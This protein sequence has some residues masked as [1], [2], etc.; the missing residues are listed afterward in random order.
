MKEVL[1]MKKIFIQALSYWPSTSPIATRLHSLVQEL[2]ANGWF[3]EILTLNESKPSETTIIENQNLKIIY[4]K[5]KCINLKG[6]IARLK[7]E[8]EFYFITKRYVRKTKNKFDYVLVS[9]PYLIPCYAGLYLK[10]KYKAKLIFDVRDIWPDVAIEMDSFGKRSIYSLCFNYISNRLYKNASFV[11][12]VSTGKVKKIQGKLKRNKEK[13][14]LVENGFEKEMLDDAYDKEFSEKYKIKNHF[15]IS[16]C[17]KVGMAQGLDKILLLAE[18]F[19]NNDNVQFLIAGDG[20]EREKIE[21]RVRKEKLNKI[22]F[23]GNVSRDHVKTILQ[24]SSMAFISLKSSKMKD[25][26]PTKLYESLAFGC[27]TLLLASGDACTLLDETGLGIHVEP[28]NIDKVI[29]AA[30]EIYNNYESFIKNKEI[31][32]KIIIDNHTRSKSSKKMV[33]LMNEKLH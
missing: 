33:N 9:S 10:K 19:K 1:D 12:T 18:N 7:K 30:E 29:N 32:K 26:I 8:L 6:V 25:T 13:V 2:I 22:I 27:P 20:V 11:T 23:T 5:Y 17:G 14:F 3:V 15:T 16:F 28:E 4:S 24:D 31:S 21:E